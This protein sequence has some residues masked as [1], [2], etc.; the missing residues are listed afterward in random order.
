[1]R[2]QRVT[3]DLKKRAG[4]RNRKKNI[5]LLK[6]SSVSSVSDQLSKS[7]QCVRMSL[8]QSTVCILAFVG[9]NV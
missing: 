3:S 5:Y 7:C 9:G 2:G 1:M 8:R 6:S 4:R